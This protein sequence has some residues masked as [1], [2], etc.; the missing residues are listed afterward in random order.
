MMVKT[1]VAHYKAAATARSVVEALLEAGFSGD[2]ISLMVTNSRGRFEDK[3][4]G[5]NDRDISPGEGAG[6]GALIGALV[7]IGSA[8]VPGIGP[9]LGSGVLAVVLTMGIGAAAG[10]VT[11]SVAAGVLDLGDE[12]SLRDD[13]TGRRYLSPVVSIVTNDQW[14]EWAEKILA[15]YQPLKIEQHEV[16]WYNSKWGVSEIQVEAHNVAHQSDSKLRIPKLP[17]ERRKATFSTHKLPGRV[18]IYDN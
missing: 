11:G 4:D 6:F 17:S 2:D 8:L 5:T 3:L 14:M 1:L 12:A 15:R 9:V 13:E 10:A 16:K 7:G 18:Q